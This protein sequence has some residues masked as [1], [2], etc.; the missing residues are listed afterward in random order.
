ML[1]SLSAS[2]PSGNNRRIKLLSTDLIFG[3][4]DNVFVYPS[5]DV[6]RL[7]DAVSRTLSFWPIVTGR[8]IVENNEDYYIEFSDQSIPFT[9]A[10]NDELDQWPNLPVI[11]DD[12]NILK[13]FIDSVQYKPETEP[14]LRLKVTRLLRSNEYIFGVSFCHLM[15]DANSNLHFLNDLSQ[16]YQQ[17]EPILPRPTFERHPLGAENRDFTSSSV[18]KLYQNVQKRETVLA[19]L[20]EEHSTTEP[21]NMSFSSEQIARLHHLASGNNCD[22]TPHDALCAYIILLLNKHAFPTRD[23]CIRRVYMLIN[24][25]NVSERLAGKSYVA[26]AIMQPLS[27]D[28]PDPCSLSSIAQTI[29]RLIKTAR[30]EEFLNNWV[31]SANTLMKQF[32]QNGEINFT[33]DKD[34]LI[35]NSN[36]KYSWTD[37]VHFGMNGQCRFHTTGL[38]KFYIRIFQLNPTVDHQGH[39]KKDQGGAEVAFRIPKGDVKEKFLQ[40]WKE[41]IAGNFKR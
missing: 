17:L 21:L 16:T 23:Q 10:E 9:Y 33:W 29:R 37:L 11:I 27:E 35:F 40:G 30:Q 6:D 8:V 24:Y 28:F 41:D 12:G 25:R 2:S 34:E 15:G 18:L 39:W 7:K 32:I 5:L 14:L 4:I 3:G 26:N 38:F 31:I 22:V 36:Y 13:P 19:R 1:S 20:A